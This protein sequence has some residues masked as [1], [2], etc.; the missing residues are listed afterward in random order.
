MDITLSRIGNQDL[1][2]SPRYNLDPDDQQGYFNR[3]DLVQYA[4]VIAY[5]KLNIL[6]IEWP[7]L[8]TVYFDFCPVLYSKKTTS[9][10]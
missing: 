8:A 3:F 1:Q 9:H 5:T 6:S 7:D 4:N 10:L 2:L